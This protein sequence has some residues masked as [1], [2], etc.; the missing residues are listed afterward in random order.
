[1]IGINKVK[2][3][4]GNVKAYWSRPPQGR[5]MSFKEI[6]AYSIGGIGANFIICMGMNLLVSAQNMIVGGAIGIAPTDMYILYVIATIA[7]IPLTGIRAN[8]IDNT[9]LRAGKYR[10]YLLSMGIPTAIISLLYVWFPYDTI[11]SIL[12]KPFMGRTQGYIITCAVVLFFNLLLQFFYNFFNDAYTN[13]VHVLSPNTQERTDV[14]AIKS[15]TYSLAPSI[16]NVV[17]PLVAQVLTNNDMYDIKVYRVTYP[18]FAIIGIILTITVFANTKEK[19]IQAKTHTVQISFMDSLKAVA[20]NKYFWIISLAGWMG[21]LETSYGNVINWSYNYGHTTNG[22]T[23]ALILTLTGN[24]SLW[25]MLLAPFCIRK[26]GKK[27]VLIGVNLFNIFFIFAMMFYVK[28]IWWLFI[29]IYLNWL[30]GAFE[31]ITAPAIQ[32]D[33][34]DYQ[35]YKSGERID[36]MFA[37]VLTIG[38]IV[39]LFTSAIVPAVQKHYGIFE[40]NGYEKPYDILDINNSGPDLLYSLLKVLIVMAGVGAIM[41]LIPYLFYDFTEKKQK[42]VVR[43]LKVRALFEDFKNGALKDE[44][45]VEAIDVV[46]YAREMA[47]K[48]YKSTNKNDYIIKDSSKSKFKLRKA[49]KKDYQE[50]LK[51]NEEIDIS[52]FVCREL[53]K[54]SLEHMK[55]EL[56]SAREVYELGLDGVRNLDQAEIKKDLDFAKSLPK[57]NIDEK[58]YR[59]FMIDLANKKLSS[60]KAYRKYYG[61]GKVLEEPDYK[62]LEEFI[63]KEDDCE[64]RINELYSELKDLKKKKQSVANVNAEI[65]K[66]KEEFINAQ[67]ATK[68]EM[69]RHAKF[70]RV[71]KAYKDCEKLIQQEESYDHYDEIALMYE[72]SKENARLERERAEADAK[73]LEAENKAFKEKLKAEKA[74]KKKN[75]K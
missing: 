33:I 71:A 58:E 55:K 63:E 68:A 14:L 4:L 35:Q 6:T 5:Y 30:V 51:F 16:M 64:K 54:F 73:R 45:L 37:A 74:A 15:V 59:E 38:N 9:R 18:V 65:K 40:G 52:K 75:N 70:N 24:A 61:G 72:T 56:A 42:S 26:W 21:F 11:E 2:N 47:E 44:A 53:D 20:K 27:K 67:K 10:P 48:D 69:D 19:I 32:A 41:N 28:S 1:M 13:L 17:Y 50:A 25:G 46:N 57:S 60:L 62:V 22:A 36:G 49:S 66:V 31:Q 29:C 43:V 3:T 23:Y 34:R 39:T 8:M 7:N 12:T